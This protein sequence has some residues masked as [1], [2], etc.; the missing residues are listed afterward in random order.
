M[1]GLL[2]SESR[3]HLGRR[4]APRESIAAIEP[5]GFHSAIQPLKFPVRGALA[6]R[7]LLAISLIACGC[8]R[9]SH[10][11][12]VGQCFH[13]EVSGP[14][15]ELGPSYDSRIVKLGGHSY[16]FEVVDW[17]PPLPGQRARFPSSSNFE[18]WDAMWDS[19]EP[20][21]DKFEAAARWEAKLREN[22]AAVR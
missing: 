11:F 1:S 10:K 22:P 16:F 21:C 9:R 14:N 3:R 6:F 7:V 13:S 4:G 18:S 19:A 20:D 2:R 5:N 12:D 17:R 15:G 8:A